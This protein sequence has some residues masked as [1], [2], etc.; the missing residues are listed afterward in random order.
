MFV[1]SFR[2]PEAAGQTWETILEKAPQ[3]FNYAF[4]T[5]KIQLWGSQVH[6]FI[7]T[8]KQQLLKNPPVRSA[9][10]RWIKQLLEFSG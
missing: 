5:R 6:S 2:L 1:Q 7:E 3:Y 8:I 4:E 10:L 9:W